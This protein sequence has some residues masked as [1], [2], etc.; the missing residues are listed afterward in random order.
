MSSRYTVEERTRFGIEKLRWLCEIAALE[1]KRRS[2]DANID[3]VTEPCSMELRAIECLA[4]EIGQTDAAAPPIDDLRHMAS[5]SL[6]F[7][8]RLH[9]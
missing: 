3:A 4:A 2:Y 1:A 9:P 6:Q 7:F 5:E 8:E